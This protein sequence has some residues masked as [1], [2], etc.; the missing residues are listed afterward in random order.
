MIILMERP[1]NGLLHF[2][3]LEIAMKADLHCHTTTSDGSMRPDFVVQAAKIFGLNTIAIT[4]HDT[5]SEIPMALEAGKKAGLTIIPGIELSAMDEQTKR[6][7]HLLCYMPQNPHPLEEVCAPTLRSRQLAAEEM[8]IQLQKWYPVP[9][10]LIRYYARNGTVL[11][12]QHIM[13]ALME[14]GYCKNIYGDLYR[15]LFHPK[16]GVIWQPVSY[17]TAK[18]ALEAAKASNG[19]VVFAHP[20][21]Y[22]SIDLLEKWVQC[23]YLDG[24]EVY[25][26][27]CTKAQSEFLYHIAEKHHL[28]MTGGSDFHGVYSSSQIRLGDVLAPENSIS[29]LLNI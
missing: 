13:H 10:Q 17:P 29:R 22:D 27:R 20:F 21:E 9:T 2:P 1:E 12:K 11:Y 24:I 14:C 19:F 3:K 16:T 23:G 15:T 6:R 28:I 18:N 7:V 5:M 25:H 8:I 26:S 4:D